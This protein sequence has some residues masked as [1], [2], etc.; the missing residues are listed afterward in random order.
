MATITSCIRPLRS[1][2][3]TVTRTCA[4]CQ[5]AKTASVDHRYEIFPP[6][7]FDDSFVRFATAP[8]MPTPATL[9]NHA[10]FGSPDHAR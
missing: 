9:K 10:S 5:R 7:A 4:F 2:P 8:L 6:S 1:S 3:S